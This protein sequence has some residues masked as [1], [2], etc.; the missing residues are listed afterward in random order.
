[1]VQQRVRDLFPLPLLSEQLRLEQNVGRSVEKRFQARM[2]INKMVNRAVLSLNSMWFGGGK[3]FGANTIDDLQVL[4]QGQRDAMLH[5]IKCVQSLGPKYEHA[6]GREALCALR[7]A[8]SSYSEPDAGVGTVVNM[9]LSKLS[10]PDGMV[11]GVSLADSLDEPLRKVVDRFEDYMLQDEGTW[12]AI[13]D[14]AAKVPPY[15]DPYLRNKKG[16]LDFLGHLYKCGVLGF[17]STCRGRVG[18]FT[19][20]KKSKV[21]DGQTVARQRLVLD[22]RQTNLQFREPP[23]TELG[24]LSA[25]GRLK[26]RGNQRLHIAGS[27]IKDCFYAVNCP[28]AMCDFFCLVHDLTH[29]EA[30]HVTGGVHDP[31]IPPGRIIPCIKVLPMGFNWSFYLIQAMHERATLRAM[32]SGRDALVLDGHPPPSLDH[33]CLAMPYCDNVHTIATD[34]S[35][36]QERCDSICNELRTMGFQLHEEMPADTRVST[37]GGE[38][39]GVKGQVRCSSK[40]MWR[41]ILAFTHITKVKVSSKTVQKLLGHAMTLCVL[42]R[43][44][45]SVFR[46]LYDFV[47]HAVEPRFLLPHERDECLMFAGIVPLLFSD[48]RLPWCPI[49]TATDASPTGF[50]ICELLASQEDAAQLGGWNERWRFRRL[51]PEHWAPR[52]RTR[53]LDVFADPRTVTRSYDNESY[54]DSYIPNSDFPEVDPGICCSKQ[55]ST[56]KMGRW[57]HTDEHITLK[58]GRAVVI[59]LR[60]LTR[61]S[62]R[63]KMSHVFLLDNLSLCFAINKGRAHSFDLLRIM[64][65]IGSISLA[66]NILISP[67]WIPSEWNPADGPSRGQIDPGAFKKPLAATVSSEEGKHSSPQRENSRQ[68]EEGEQ[69]LEASDRESD[70]ER[71]QDESRIKEPS[72]EGPCGRRFQEVKTLRPSSEDHAHRKRGESGH[73]GQERQADQAGAEEHLLREPAAV[74]VLPGEVQGL[75]QGERRRY[76]KGSRRFRPV[77]SRLH[78][79]LVSGRVPFTRR[80]EDDGCSGVPLFEGEGKAGAQQTGRQGLEED[81]SYHQPFAVAYDD[82]YGYGD[83]PSCS[84]LLGHGTDGACGLPHV[85]ETGGGQRAQEETCRSSCEDGGKPIRMDQCHH[86]GSG[87]RTSR[88]DRRFR[89]QPPIRSE[90]VGVG[91]PDASQES[92]VVAKQGVTNLHL[93]HGELQEGV[94]SVSH[95][96]GAGQHPSIPDAPRWSHGRFVKQKAGFRRSEDQR[97]VENRCQRSAL[98]QDRASSA[99]AGRFETKQSAVL[100]MEPNKHVQ[101]VP[102]DGPPSPSQLKA[103]AI[104]DVFTCNSKPRQFALE[105]FAGCAALSR[106]LCSQRIPTFPIDICLHSTHDVLNSAVEKRIL[107]WLKSGR[108]NLVWLGMP[109]TSFSRARKHDG[110]GPGPIRS[111]EF[112]WGLPSLSPKDR[113]KVRDGN[114]LLAFLLRII[115]ACEL[116]RIPYVVENP[117][118]SMLW[119]MPTMLRFCKRYSPSKIFLDYCA[120]GMPWKKP[121]ALMYN[122]LRLESLEQQCHSRGHA[123]Q[124]SHKPHVPLRGRDSTGTFLT[125]R[126]QPYPE[127]LCD[128]FAS[129]ARA[130]IVG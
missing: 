104:Q 97:K 14:E 88:Q 48:M 44:G 65:Q 84:K 125:L 19:V 9:C 57:Q 121:T 40:R 87:V 92:P 34:A 94:F 37:L 30:L 112:L 115:S 15:N 117:A 70:E 120:Y 116:Y 52:S 33:G 66:A 62:A 80:G 107:F 128:Q 59:A 122:F 47:E 96:H 78:G 11:A 61:S 39:D 101:S 45:M 51:A 86:T 53:G 17:T 56:K 1:M 76:A 111:S 4:S 119:E 72:T 49:I 98:C 106:A 5:I 124:F 77:S 79:R 7:A 109:C 25:L 91:G 126:A 2:A 38:I 16:Y 60:R 3:R 114:Y 105:V 118:T 74:P 6:S 29:D 43:A 26:L 32:G 69:K 12:A 81:P 68:Q 113:R 82:P 127:R 64:Q 13:Q 55:W 102:G 46:Y 20:A 35:V 99:V 95:G 90:G 83:G 129:L 24:S 18:A 41:L 21:I 123:C 63:R 22:C 27:D 100:Q 89:Q 103:M 75:L 93:Q 23:L 8:S 42:H 54:L 130:Q 28:K 36:C 50:G 108:I 85:P 110:L 10:L 31:D 67:R 58:E 73:F 71:C